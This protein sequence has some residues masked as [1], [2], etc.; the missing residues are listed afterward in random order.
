LHRKPASKSRGVT[1]SEVLVAAVISSLALSLVAALAHPM[2]TAAG[3]EQAKV[4]TVATIVQAQ[5]R[6]QRDARQSDPNGIFVC[7]NAGGTFSCTPASSFSTPT[8]ATYLA[9][10]TIHSGGDGPIN[11]DSSGR[12]AWSGFNVY[13]LT[14]D[15]A[16][17]NTLW[18]S[19]ASA[20]IPPGTSPTVLNAD[21]AQAVSSAVGASTA[22]LV[23]H[24]V[25]SMQV[26]VDTA[27]D[28]TALRLYA[29]AT[30]GQ[31]INETSVESDTYA[32]N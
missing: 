31:S 6:L 22:L 20:T 21:V 8:G 7:S 18:F 2:L 5:Y 11:W 1:L 15:G 3:A 24:S 17:A 32:R 28:R 13:W 25:A 14:S 12:P 9:I 29:Q 10:L 26:M 19:F 4:D 30:T 23:A 16:G 27:T